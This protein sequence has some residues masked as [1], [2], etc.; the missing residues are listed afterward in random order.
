MWPPEAARRHRTEHQTPHLACAEGA[1]E[2]DEVV[3]EGSKPMAGSAW[4]AGRRLK[5]G[6]RL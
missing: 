1:L 4:A 5:A 3:P 6:D 2:L